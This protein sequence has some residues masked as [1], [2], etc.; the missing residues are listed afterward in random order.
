MKSFLTNS[1][2][3]GAKQESYAL[4]FLRHR[5]YRCVARNYSS[6]FGE[7]DLIVWSNDDTLVFVE[8]RYRRNTKFGLPAETVSYAKQAKLKK[9]AAYFLSRNQNFAGISCRFDVIGI[10]HSSRLDKN[11]IEW[12]KNA[13]Y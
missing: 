13:F 5:G 1:R 12:I 4:K 2:Q 10:T 8:I 7:I 3:I 11:S 9:T 6:R